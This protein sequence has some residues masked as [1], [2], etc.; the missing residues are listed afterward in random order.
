MISIV[1]MSAVVVN[2]LAGDDCLLGGVE[3]ACK[4]SLS[5]SFVTCTDTDGSTSTQVMISA[6]QR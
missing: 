5:G 6:D 2:V 3:A 4:E 1:L